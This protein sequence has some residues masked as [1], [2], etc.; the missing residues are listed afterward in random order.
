VARRIKIGLKMNSSE[1][2]V[3]AELGLRII[4]TEQTAVPLAGGLFYSREDPYAV[5]IVIHVGLDEP[6]EWIFARDLLSMGTENR[7]GIGDVQVWPSADPE[8]RA[9]GGVLNIEL[10]SPFG[11]AHLKAPANQVSDFLRRAYRIVPAGEESGHIDLA[12]ELNDLLR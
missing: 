9:P 12:A 7:K 1:N 6:V 8:G 10:S 4:A 11:R 2:T 3:S 5:R